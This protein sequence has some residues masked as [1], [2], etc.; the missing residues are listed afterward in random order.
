MNID[1]KLG[2]TVR[3]T[4]TGFTGIAIRRCDHLN[5]NVQYAV[6]PK[7]K[8]G[9]YPEAV[10]LDYH[11]LDV[12]DDGVSDRATPVS[13]TDIILGQKVRDKATGFAGIAATKVKRGF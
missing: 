12:I 6:Q 5:G 2:S 1:I 10:F 7:G 4:I 13:E 8:D 9:S 11:T 3:D